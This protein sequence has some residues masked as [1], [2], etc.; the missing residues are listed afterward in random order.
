[1]R[2]AGQAVQRLMPQ[3]DLADLMPV[4]PVVAIRWLH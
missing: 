4:A 3:V 1:M 2:L